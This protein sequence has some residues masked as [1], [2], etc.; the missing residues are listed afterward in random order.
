MALELTLGRLSAVH[1]AVG[2]SRHREFAGRVYKRKD[3]YHSYTPPLPR[4]RDS[5][6]FG[7]CP[8]GTANSGAIPYAWSRVKRK[9]LR[10]CVLRLGYELVGK[11]KRPLLSRNAEWCN[12][13]IHA[14]PR[15]RALFRFCR[16]SCKGCQMKTLNCLI[17]SIQVFFSLPSWAGTQAS[18][19]QNDAM[20]GYIPQSGFVPD[21]KTAVAV[22]V[23]VL[24]PIYGEE[25]VRAKYPYIAT[26]K[27]GR[28]TVKGSLPAHLVGGVPEVQLLRSS[29]KIVKVSAG[30]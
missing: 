10:L 4:K 19:K 21:S 27:N 22:A 9:K 1:A 6:D 13:K 20:E 25:E 16:S 18:L 14:N 24:I 2:P 11:R 30:K 17:L 23:A 12:R 7:S 28:W 15:R 3:G 26:L 8:P 29:G 5:A